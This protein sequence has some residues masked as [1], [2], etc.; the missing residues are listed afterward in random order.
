MGII[1]IFPHV[2]A[3]IIAQNVEKIDVSQKMRAI[4]RLERVG[5]YA[6]AMTL[7][8]DLYQYKPGDRLIVTALNRLYRHIEPSALV[9]K[10]EVLVG[11]KPNDVNYRFWLGQGYLRSGQED[12]A[13]DQFQFIMKKKPKDTNTS[14]QIARC[15]MANGLYDHAVQVYLQARDAHQDA[16]LFSHELA[17]I[18]ERQKKYDRGAKE[19]LRWMETQPKQWA[20]VEQRLFR[21]LKEIREDVSGVDSSQIVDII[22]E[23]EVAVQRNKESDLFYR[24]LGDLYVQTGFEDKAFDCYDQVEAL[25]PQQGKALMDF[26]DRCL[27]GGHYTT[28]TT[29][30]QRLIERFPDSR[31]ALNA[32]LKI[33]ESYVRQD[34]YKK[35]VVTYQG[36]ARNH[37]DRP[38]AQQA[39]AFVGDI[40]LDHLNNPEGALDTYQKFEEKYRAS[41]LTPQILFRIGEAYLRSGQPAHAESIWCQFQAYVPGKKKSKSIRFVFPGMLDSGSHLVGGSDPRVHAEF[42]CALIKA[43]HGDAET[44]VAGLDEFVKKYAGDDLINDALQWAFFLTEYIQTD[45]SRLGLYLDAYYL[46]VQNQSDKAIDLYSQLIVLPDSL[47][48]VDEPRLADYALFQVAN[49]R[50]E[51]SDQSG[52][53]QNFRS[54]V[55][56]FPQSALAPLSQMMIGEMYARDLSQLDQAQAEYEVVL[57]DFPESVYVEEARRQ[58]QGLR[59]K[60]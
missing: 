35:A 8:E 42:Q 29:A 11:T 30:F 19:Y 6:Q 17:Q 5:N 52:A 36:I 31:H 1:S 16:T 40:Y 20:L 25:R 45:P 4:N 48:Q 24:V 26:G 43:L 56:A 18:Y 10:Y 32:E 50:R 44:C 15:Y 47:E 54:I 23:A 9:A 37:P 22:S 33:G 38:E 53:I 39:L 41:S 14:L 12:Q 2:E 60:P 3:Q 27:K 21:F 7:A 59:V 34:Q 58:I 57:T 49:L 51:I 46:Q 28:A 13:G 55:R